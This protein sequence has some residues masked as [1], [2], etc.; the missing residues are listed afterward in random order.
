MQYPWVSTN[1]AVSAD[2]KISTPD[3]RPSGWTSREDHQRLL[4]LRASAD[5][6]LVGRATLMADKMRMLV[7]N[8]ESQPLRCIISRQGNI[9][10]E[11]PIFHC[12]GGQIHLL[13]TD[14]AANP[15]VPAR[16]HRGEL[17]GFL[18]TLKHEHG[19]S[20]LHCE[21]GGETIRRLATLGAIDEFHLTLA[22]HTVLGG[23]TSPTATGAPGEFLPRSAKFELIDFEPRPD[24]GE[25]FLSYRRAC[26]STAQ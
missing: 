4:R 6:L 2:G 9:P 15:A 21:G 10:L 20:R 8:R 11:H 17:S 26:R 5:A 12:S 14:N 24:L 25:C 22:G 19:I 1:L 23:G 3:Q 16:I 7:P 18:R 13:V